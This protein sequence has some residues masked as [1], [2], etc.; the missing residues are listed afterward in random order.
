MTLAIMQ[1]YLLPY[2]GYY[3]L[4]MAVDKFVILDDVAFINR[5]WINRNRILVNGVAQYFTVPLESASQ[6][7]M[8]SETTVISDGK[9]KI[10][11]ERTVEMAYKKAP[12]FK[13][14]FPLF[15]SIIQYSDLNLSAFL[16]HSAKLVNEFL[17]IDKTLVASSAIYGNRHLKGQARIID[18]CRQEKASTYINPPGGRALYDA[19][20]F[21]KQN[22]ELLFLKPELN[23]YPQQGI[24]QFIP[25][26]SILDQ[27][28]NLD[29]QVVLN[30]LN[31]Y[32]LEP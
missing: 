27:L 9:W 8:I 16:F 11:L 30:Q 23:E 21:S 5:G 22:I 13:E 31:C 7:K 15:A 26:L 17:G 1:P 6:N 25:G 32:S 29:K 18:I 19:G 3:Q 10:K 14:V 12:F 20:L 28:M 4:M 24:K 2:A